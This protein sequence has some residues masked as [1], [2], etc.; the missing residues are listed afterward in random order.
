MRAVVRCVLAVIGIA[1]S[2]VAGPAGI[3]LAAVNQSYGFAIASVLP[4]RARW[5]VWRTRGGDVQRAR[6]QPAG[7]RAWH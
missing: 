3:S 4:T 2:V 6:R 7:G 5:W 1:A